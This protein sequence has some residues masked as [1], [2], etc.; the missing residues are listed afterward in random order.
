[1]AVE[2][3]GTITPT[4]RSARWKSFSIW[5]VLS[6]IP[7]KRRVYVPAIFRSTHFSRFF[8]E[9]EEVV[10]SSSHLFRIKATIGKYAHEFRN[11]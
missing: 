7:E 3:G 10:E 5:I 2:D 8:S 9:D 1:M 4:R 6:K 11:K